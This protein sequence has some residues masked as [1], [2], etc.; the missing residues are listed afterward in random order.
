M[1]IL[2][3]VIIFFAGV[4]LGVFIT[5]GCQSSVVPR[6]LQS[7]LHASMVSGGDEARLRNLIKSGAPF[8][9]IVA[10]SGDSVDAAAYLR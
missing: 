9:E 7:K 4:S 1:N 6:G 8:S 10:A 3:A 5:S 2:I